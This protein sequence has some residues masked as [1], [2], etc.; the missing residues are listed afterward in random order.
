MIRSLLIGGS[1]L[2]VSLGASGVAAAQAAP[3][4]AAAAAP[5]PGVDD[6]W[7][8]V[9]R[10]VYAFNAVLDR[11]VLRPGVVFYHHATPTPIRRGLHN[12]LV[13]ATHPVIII[14]DAL[15]LRPVRALTALGRFTVN[16]TVG[17]GGVFDV[18]G[19]D[20]PYHNADFG[21]TLA[22]YG[23]PQGP[24]VYLPVLG[25]TTIRDGAGRI[26]DG[27]VDPLNSVNYSGRE[28][29]APTR[30]IV[31]G[32]D[33]R[34]QLDPLIKDVNRTA[35]DPYATIRSAYLQ[36]RQAE[37]RGE[38]TSA[39]NVQALPDFGPPSSSPS[40]STGATP[41]PS[42]T[43]AGA[44]GEQERPATPPPAAPGPSASNTPASTAP[45]SGDAV[46]DLIAASPAS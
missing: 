29:L 14:N 7:E 26:V 16:S 27:V 28:V 12:V 39:A 23:V 13:N 11:R 18:A 25:P 10:R 24:Y 22:R 30:A 32:I 15:Q 19:S 21:L 8:G 3:P 5:S 42:P 17:V 40:R 36:S 6:P 4:A 43:D 1:A 46:A 9:N 2:A 37:V 33:A 20:L 31:G 45:I 44:E 35:T 41:S 38:E 34:D